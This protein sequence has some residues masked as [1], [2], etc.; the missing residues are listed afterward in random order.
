VT[1]CWT[2]WLPLAIACIFLFGALWLLLS[3]H[4]DSRIEQGFSRITSGMDER[5]VIAMM[6]KPHTVG[7]C[8]ELGGAPGGCTREYLYPAKLSIATTWAI[9]FDAQGRVIDKDE[10]Q[11]P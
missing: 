1:K 2:R 5:E 10:Y 3:Y 8:G 6:G 7:K 11:S 4:H 9:F